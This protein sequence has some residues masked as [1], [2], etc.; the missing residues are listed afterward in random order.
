MPD[1]D[2]V[3]A[4]YT[5]GRL[6]DAIAE[7]VAQLGKTIET[8]TVEDLGPVDEFHVGGRVATEAFLDQLDIGAEHH[9]LDVGCGLGGASRFAAARYGCRV[10]GVDLTPEYVAT[11][12]TL[13]SWVGLG[14][15]VT[16]EVGDATALK[17]ENDSFDRAFVM[18][19]GMNIADKTALTAELFRV[20][21]PGGLAG[22]Y[23]VML[24]GDG[25][26]SYP[27]PWAASAAGSA[28]ATPLDYR[29][30]LEAAGF[31][32]V[33]ERNRRD[34]AVEFFARLKAR[35]EGAGG[36]PPL[37]IHLLMGDTAPLKVRNM[38]E[39]IARDRIAPVELV[40]EKPA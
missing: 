21:R 28:L 11:G 23:D 16:L 34:F 6:V 15:R 33:A 29:T 25:A 36:P 32:V 1:R 40:A 26:L 9:V 7:G 18:H 2:L 38:I 39:N 12:N 14:D 35:A 24:S 10:T 4:H 27:V 22:I 13:C 5:H 37:G 30:A 20:L 8:V 19:V 17:Q 31:R 3:S